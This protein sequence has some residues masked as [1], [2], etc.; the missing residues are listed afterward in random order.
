MSNG[1][2]TLVTPKSTLAQQPARTGEVR[3]D[4]ERWKQPTL[5]TASN[6]QMA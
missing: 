6:D 4:A 2:A 3:N 5:P 1:Q